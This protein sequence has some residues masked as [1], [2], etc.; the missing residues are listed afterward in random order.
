M[1]KLNSKGK[2]RKLHHILFLF[3]ETFMEMGLE[4]ANA[5]DDKLRKH[6]FMG[7]IPF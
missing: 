6:E 1:T 7:E 4:H 3:S 5:Y 2:N